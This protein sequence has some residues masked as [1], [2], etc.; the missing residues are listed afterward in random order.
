[1]RKVCAARREPDDAKREDRRV[2]RL[3]GMVLALGV[4]AGLALMPGAAPRAQDALDCN[5]C[6]DTGDLAKKSVSGSRLKK[7]AVKANRIKDGAV[8]GPKIGAGAVDSDK[9]ALG[10]VTGDKLAAGAVAGANIAAGAVTAD[11]LDPEVLGNA[12]SFARTMVVSPVGDGTD[13][14][15]NGQALL[16]A[17]AALDTVTPPP[18]AGNPWLIKIE[19]GVYD[20]GATSVQMRQ[21]VD[22]AG[23]GRDATTI[24]GADSLAIVQGANDAELRSLRVEH[25]GVGAGNGSAIAAQN[26]NVRITDVTAKAINAAIA[27]IGIDAWGDAVLTNVTAIGDNGTGLAGIGVWVLNNGSDVQ[28]VNST[29]IGSGDGSVGAGLRVTNTSVVTVRNSVIKGIG[30]NAVRL[31]L[32]SPSA[33]FVSTQLDGTFLDIATGTT[34]TCVGA[35]DGAFGPLGANCN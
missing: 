7:A 5:K 27:S 14:A 30:A 29:A 17:L 8:T 9:V 34:F 33:F 32:I 18:G 10:A 25:L 15:A 24:R 11:K 28:L 1:M 2:T 23:A 12:V 4:A 22:M 26:S 35:Y 16:D 6:V 20:V 21:F 3:A 31:D 19:A 13:F